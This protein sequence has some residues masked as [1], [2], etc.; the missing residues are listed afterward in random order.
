MKIAFYTPFLDTVGGGE[1]YVL[2]VAEYLSA[3]H[4]VDVLLDTHLASFDLDSI[5]KRITDLHNLNLSKVNFIEAPLGKGSL[6]IKRLL[7]LKKYDFLFY[8]TDGSI[9]YSTAKNSIL[10]IQSP[11]KNVN[12]TPKGKIKLFS[13]KMIIYNSK[14]T[15]KEAQ[16]S[17]QLKSKVIYPPVSV[18]EIRPLKKKKQIISVGRFFGFLKDK[19]HGFLIDAFKKLVEENN[20]DGWSLHLVGGAMDGDKPYLEELKDQAKGAKIFLHPNLPFN[21]LKKFYGESQIYW[22]AAGFGED[23]PTKMEHFGI[24]TVEAMA[25]GCVPVVIRK[26]GQVE[27]IENGKSGFLWENAEELLKYTRDL[28]GDSDQKDKLSKEA[29]KRCKMFSKEKFCQNIG[30]IV[31]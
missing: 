12:N 10:H 2:T 7:F 25:G 15:Q 19:K 3:K 24:S 21:D 30:E 27:I 18:S 17:W 4:N 11:I 6:Q 28:M 22:H 8:L 20:L 9:F 16:K 31:S 13:W 1:K 14:F 29:V 23:D 26:G 5:K